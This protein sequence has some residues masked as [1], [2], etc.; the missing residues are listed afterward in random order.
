MHLGH[1]SNVSSQIHRRRQDKAALP[2]Q[3]A[4]SCIKKQP[5]QLDFSTQNKGNFVFILHACQAKAAK[6]LFAR[7]KLAYLQSKYAV[8]VHFALHQAYDSDIAAFLRASCLGSDPAE[9][10]HNL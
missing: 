1:S 7:D 9:E 5:F 3:A 8:G 4:A 6:S 2:E 10:G